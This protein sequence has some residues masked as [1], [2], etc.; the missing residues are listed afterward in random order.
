MAN[1]GAP[2][3][4]GAPGAGQRRPRRPVVAVI[5]VLVAAAVLSTATVLAARWVVSPHDRAAGHRPG[6]GFVRLD[7]PA[8]PVSLPSLRGGGKIDLAELA[9]KPIVINF[10]QPNCPPCKQETPALARAA[11]SLAG[12]VSFLGINSA[13]DSR[14]RALAFVAQYKVPYPIGF[15]P[16]ATVADRYGAYWLPVTFFL[17]PSGKRIVGENVGAL[18]AAKLRR[19]LHQLYRVT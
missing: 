7:R 13:F 17:S 6:P 4:A 5:L 3:A 11:K 15:D 19:I 10:W 9:G 2:S 18:T 12:K 16:D 14:P 1:P 8:A